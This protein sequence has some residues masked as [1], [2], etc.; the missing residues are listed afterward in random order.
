[1]V[2]CRQLRRNVIAQYE[3]MPAL[4]QEK[5]RSQYRWVFTQ[6]KN[7]RGLPKMWMHHLEHS[8]FTC[9]IMGLR[10]DWP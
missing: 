3:S 6:V 9:H 8:K 5:N 2:K 7:I 10:G 1:M 4:H